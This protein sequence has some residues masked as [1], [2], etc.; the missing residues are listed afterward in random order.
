MATS[1]Y[2]PF[3]YPFVHFPFHTPQFEVLPGLLPQRKAE[4]TNN[5]HPI[6]KT[7]FRENIDYARK[8]QDS[9][10]SLATRYELDGPGIESHWGSKI[11]R[12]RPNRSGAQPAPYTMGTESFPGVK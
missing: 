3:N 8:G 2:I 11:F 6:A 12:A 7:T 10:V 4:N 5:R 1:I 9:S